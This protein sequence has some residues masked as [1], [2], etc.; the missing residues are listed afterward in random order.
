MT[1]SRNAKIGI[2]VVALAA[3]SAGIYFFVINK[4]KNAI[5]KAKDA[6][7]E[8]TGGKGGTPAGA[9]TK[10]PVKGSLPRNGYADSLPKK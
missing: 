6:K 3:I 7:G 2:G 1:L 10:P 4:S 9:D 5:E 8:E